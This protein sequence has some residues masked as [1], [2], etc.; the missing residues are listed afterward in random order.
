MFFVPKGFNP[1]YF[2]AL[3]K[4]T[5]PS[6]QSTKCK[7]DKICSKCSYWVCFTVMDIKVGQY[8]DS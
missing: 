2:T 7:N 3:L 8:P 4:D 1:E 5:L 6:P